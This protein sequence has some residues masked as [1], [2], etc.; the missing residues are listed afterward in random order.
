MINI[1]ED[2]DWKFYLDYYKDLTDTGLRTERDAIN[3]YINHGKYENRIYKNNSTNENESFDDIFIYDDSID[4]TLTNNRLPELKFIIDN[5]KL[6]YN[7]LEM[8][9]YLSTALNNLNLKI[10]RVNINFDYPSEIIPKLGNLNYL[11]SILDLDKITDNYIENINKYYDGIIV[12]DET[13][14]TFYED[15][16]VFIPIYIMEL[17]SRSFLNFFN[18]EINKNRIGIITTWNTRCGI[19]DYTKYMTE[20]LNDYKIFSNIDNNI[21]D[22]D[23]DK[24]TNRCFSHEIGIERLKKELLR[25]NI[26]Y[27]IMNYHFGFFSDEDL[28]NLSKFLY[29]KSI[30]TV[31]ILHNSSTISD[32]TFKELEKLEA[33]LVHTDREVEKLSPIIKNCYKFNHPV[34]VNNI[35]DIDFDKGD[36]TLFSS[37]GFIFEDKKL[38]KLIDVF[39]QIYLKDKKVKLLLLNAI[40]FLNI[41]T[42]KIINEVKAKISDYD[43]EDNVIMINEFL[44][45]EV[46]TS[47]LSKSDFIIFLRDNTTESSSASVRTGLSTNVPVICEKNDIYVDVEKYVSFINDDTPINMANNIL[48]LINSDTISDKLI[49]QKK[50]LNNNTW[51]NGVIYLKNKLGI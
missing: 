12:L 8:E 21:V 23:S 31:I 11:F 6:R 2:F 51:E 24:Y 7:E 15:S 4:I 17:S 40:H 13:V 28:M 38:K 20:Y 36:Y 33:V 19:A 18:N 37:F 14:K 10:G 1:P 34:K 42:K 32:K 35:V 44:P 43:I 9:S 3:H 50:W 16:G 5:T 39:Y 49:E 29:E 22:K 46:L 48:E 41:E 26:N 47:S 45:L 25:E 30:K 27:L